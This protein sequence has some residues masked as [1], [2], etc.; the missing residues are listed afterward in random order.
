MKRTVVGFVS[1]MLVL[2]LV[3]AGCAVPFDDIG[4]ARKGATTWTPPGGTWLPLAAEWSAGI[5]GNSS[6]NWGD[7][8]ISSNSQI[9][10]AHGV[11]FNFD[12]KNGFGNDALLKITDDFKDSWAKGDKDCKGGIK[13]LVLRIQV[14]NLYYTVDIPSSIGTGYFR[15]PLPNSNIKVNNAWLGSIPCDCG[16]CDTDPC[17]CIACECCDAIEE[18]CGA[19]DCD[20]EASKCICCFNETFVGCG[21]CLECVG[22]PD[23]CIGCNHKIEC[24][25]PLC[26][27][28]CV[29][30]RCNDP[31]CNDLTIFGVCRGPCNCAC[32]CLIPDGNW[33][34][35]RIQSHS[36]D[37]YWWNFAKIIAQIDNNNK[38]N[39]YGY[40]YIEVAANY[41]DTYY[42]IELAINR[43]WITGGDPSRFNVVRPGVSWA[44][45]YLKV[46]TIDDFTLIGNKL[47]LNL[48][49]Y[50]GM[51]AGNNYNQIILIQVIA[52]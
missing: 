26:K 12:G 38:D 30:G 4:S 18:L 21:I 6:S 47:V 11:F 7:V 13:A 43:Q 23:R 51:S 31:T 37:A 49:K 19:K 16:H 35:M 42:G 46:F 24:T 39:N 52:K 36:Q 34:G 50:F 17:V 14:Q 1:V 25:C 8:K 32:K 5:P 22:N 27:L 3:L 29:N 48:D 41:F 28:P 20:K 2:G 10:G 40:P 45:N 9:R 44:A 15:L 33:S